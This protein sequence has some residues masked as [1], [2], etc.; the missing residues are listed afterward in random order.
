MFYKN[1]IL[2]LPQSVAPDKGIPLAGIVLHRAKKTPLT[3][4]EYSVHYGS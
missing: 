3:Y 4:V 1:L 2:V